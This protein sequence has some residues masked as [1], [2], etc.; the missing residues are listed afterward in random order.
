MMDVAVS[1]NRYKF[2]GNEFLTWLWYMIENETDEMVILGAESA[3]LVI[4]NRLVLENHVQEGVETVTIKGDA[5]G[6]E[7]GLLSLKKGAMVTQINL[8]YSD[9][10]HQWS[11]GV[12]GENLDLG[13]LKAPETGK[14]ESKEDIEG[15]L[16][17]KMALYDK[18]FKVVDGLFAMFVTDRLSS[19]WMERWVPK[20]RGWIQ[21]RSIH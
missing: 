15:A 1:Y 11:F 21:G 9:G 4:G 2:L 20:I 18:A 5:A 12:K 3:S 19:V 13:N 17:E 8:I 6:L 10:L 16:I 14:V 7:E